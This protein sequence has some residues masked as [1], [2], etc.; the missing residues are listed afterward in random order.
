MIR[1]RQPDVHGPQ[2]RGGIAPGSGQPAG[3]W[4]QAVW[5]SVFAIMIMWLG[6]STAKAQ[7]AELEYKVKAAFLYNFIGFVEWPTNKLSRADKEVI[8]GCLPDDPATPVLAHALEGKIADGRR[9]KVVTL[10][11]G[12]EA[13]SC[14]LLFI[15]RSRRGQIG[16]VLTRLKKAPVLTVSEV[17]QFAERGGMINLVRHERTFRFE[18]NLG[19]AERAGLRIS[20]KLSSMATLIK[21]TAPP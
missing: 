6:V 10:R 18:V 9:I 21:T 8:I 7:D 2:A 12:E 11:E 4:A 5:S 19:A 3:R 20:S 13:E 17:E 15:S 1:K 14:H 16:D